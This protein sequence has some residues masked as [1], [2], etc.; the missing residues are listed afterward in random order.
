MRIALLLYGRINRF[1]EHYENI[2][3]SIGKEHDIDIF[4]SSDNSPNDSLQEFVELYKP[5]LYIND[6]IEHYINVDKYTIPPEISVTPKN[7]ICHFINKFRV[8]KL[9]EQYIEHTKVNYDIV[10]ST[11]IDL[12]F[13]SKFIFNKCE[14]KTLYIPPGYDYTTIYDNKLYLSINDQIAYGDI[15]SMRLYMNI[16]FN[17]IYFLDTKLSFLHPETLT[18]TNIICN[19]LNIIRF[20]LS[21]YIE[22]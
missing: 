13:D 22:R 7:M 18:Y 21:Y 5:K 14:E 10:L 16:I 20:H 15:N 19:N 17:M 11:R 8:F 6:K 9:L 2:L 12:V 4:L 1:K 3:D